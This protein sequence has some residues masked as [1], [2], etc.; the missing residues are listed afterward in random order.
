VNS[1]L[2][3]TLIRLITS[4]LILPLLLVHLLPFNF[5]WLNCLLAVIFALLALT[6]LFD[7]YLARRYNQETVM[8][9]ILDPIADKF[10]LYSTLVALVAANKL[11]FMW[12]VIF[13]GREFLVMALRQI[14][15]EHHFTIPVSY[16]AKSKTFVQMV[17]LAIIIAN[18]FTSLTFAQAPHWNGIQ[19][20]FLL[21][22][23]VLS[24][25]S[26]W[27]YYYLCMEQLAVATQEKLA[28]DEFRNI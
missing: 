21:M 24:I 2:Y 10:L 16:A 26:A 18:P 19:I 20:S 27:D 12:A 17:Y 13:I 11:W 7:G 28:E 22:S 6:D 5:L 1:P 23:L 25:Y 8:G 15:L 14:A 9:K 4:P 3:L